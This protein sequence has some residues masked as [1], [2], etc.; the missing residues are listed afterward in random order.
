MKRDDIEFCAL[1]GDRQA[2]HSDGSDPHPLPYCD[3]CV[4]RMLAEDSGV[5]FHAVT[6]IGHSVGVLFEQLRDPAEVR[7]VVA[8]ALDQVLSEA[9]GNY[10]VDVPRYEVARRF[11]PLEPRVPA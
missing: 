11:R 10:H 6:V 3:V 4:Q 1:C 9:P 8:D 2:T 5:A 7:R